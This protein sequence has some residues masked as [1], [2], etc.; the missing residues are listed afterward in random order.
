MPDQTASAT[1]AERPASGSGAAILTLG[2]LAAAFGLASCCALPLLLTSAGIGTAWLYGFAVAAAPHRTLL[3]VVGTACL[4][5]G[6][7]LLWRQQRA[8]AACAA[9]GICGRPAV[10]ALI[11]VGL[12]LCAGLLCAG[13]AYA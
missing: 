9:S 2:G 4:F 3:L 6:S 1:V 5:G 7:V 8:S 10:R 11:F 12:L 13:Y